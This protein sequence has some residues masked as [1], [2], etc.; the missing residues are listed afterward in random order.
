MAWMLYESPN[1]SIGT[2]DGVATLELHFPGMPGNVWNLAR[3][4]EFSHAIGL[5]EREPAVETAVLRSGTPTGFCGGFDI[6]ALERIDAIS[7]ANAGQRVCQQL[8]QASFVSIAYLEG[9]CL[10]PGFDIAL[11]CDD[12][13]AVAGPNSAIG[14]G[15]APTGWGGFTRLKWRIGE[16][17]AKQFFGQP[18]TPREA[19]MLGAIDHAFCE[20]RAKIELQTWLDRRL[21]NPMKRGDGWRSRFNASEVGFARERQQFAEAVRFGYPEIVHENYEPLPKSIEII[22]NKLLALEYA[23]RGVRVSLSGSFTIHEADFTHRGRL[24]PL[25]AANAIKLITLVLKVPA[26][27]LAPRLLQYAA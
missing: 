6:E 17:G 27:T 3:L 8:Q 7:F 21:R 9:P 4:A 19:V 2:C 15:N 16:R 13:L 1:I 12:R 24:T 23:M 25:E 26:E 22:G 20:R 14:F 18:R 5:I 10:G 11:A